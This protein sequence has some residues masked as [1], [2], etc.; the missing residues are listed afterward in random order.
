MRIFSIGS[1]Q[2]CKIF[3]FGSNGDY[4]MQSNVSGVKLGYKEVIHLAIVL[5]LLL[6]SWLAGHQNPNCIFV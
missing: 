3:I 2:C 1:L 4:F 6:L 5:L